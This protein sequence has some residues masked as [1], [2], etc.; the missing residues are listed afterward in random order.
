MIFSLTEKLKVFSFKRGFQKAEGRRQWVV[1]FIRSPVTGNDAKRE[2]LV[3][4]AT[5][6]FLLRAAVSQL[7]RT[8]SGAQPAAA[9]RCLAAAPFAQRMGSVRGFAD[10]AKDTKEEFLAKWNEVAPCTLDPPRYV[11]LHSRPPRCRPPDNRHLFLSLSLSLVAQLCFR[12]SGEERGPPRGRRPRA[13]EAH[14]LV[15]PSAREAIQ[16]SP[17]SPLRPS[18]MTKIQ[19]IF[20]SEPLTPTFLPT[21]APPRWT[22]SSC[23]RSLETSE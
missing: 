9:L 12:V 16:V 5:M 17:L 3:C 14:L 13:L 2:E 8:T 22:W 6:A 19:F 21:P 7:A 15:L 18:L 11:R 23:Q 4:L 1:F 10:E 20:F